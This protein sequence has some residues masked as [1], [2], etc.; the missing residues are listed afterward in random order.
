MVLTATKRIFRRS[1][2][3]TCETV[4][5]VFK[6]VWRLCCKINVVCMSLS[7]FDSF[8]SR[9]VT[10]LLNFPRSSVLKQQVSPSLSATNLHKPYSISRCIK[11]DAM[12]FIHCDGKIIIHYMFIDKHKHFWFNTSVHLYCNTTTCFGSL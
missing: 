10:Y 4:G 11:S 1:F 7:P 3:G 12:T 9:F 6:S 2:P 5:Q 8:Q